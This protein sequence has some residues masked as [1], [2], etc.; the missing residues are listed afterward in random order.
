MLASH[1]VTISSTGSCTITAT[2]T[3]GTE[4]GTSNS[5][6][7]SASVSKFNACH[8]YATTSCSTASGKLYTRLAGTAFATDVAALNSSDAVATGFTGKAVVSLIARATPGGVDADNCFAPDASQTLDN[9]VTSFTSGKLTVNA[10]VASAYREAR[11]KVVCDSTN[12]PPGGVT[13]CSADNFAIRPTAI[14]LS[15]TDANADTSG[16][17]AS[18]TPAVKTGTSFNLTA[19]AVASYNGTPQIDTA[20]LNAHAGAVQAGSL[21]GSFGAAAPGTGIATGSFA[22]SEVGYFNLSASGLYDDSY[23][24]V[25]QPNDCTNDFSNVPASGKYGCKFR[26]TS[27]SVFVGRFVPDHF[28]LTAGSLIDR[29]GI[30]TGASET[31]CASSFTYMGESFKTIF[32]LEAQN[33]GN[34]TTQNYTGAHA[35]FGLTTWSNY[36]F[37]GSSGTLAEGSA[38]P[39]GNWGSTV[40]TYGKA[41]VTATHKVTRPGSPAAPYTNFVVSAQPSYTDGSA[42]YS[43]AASTAVHPGNTLQRYGRLRILGAYGSEL[44]PLRVPVRAEYHDG[45]TWLA[46]AADNCTSLAANTVALSGGISTNTSASAVSL[47]GGAGTLTLAKPSPTATGLVDL[48]INLGA[49]GTTNTDSC[50]ATNPAATAANMPWLQFAWCTGKL[51]PNAR[52]RFGSPRAPFIYLRERF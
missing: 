33:S 49:T 10:T 18:A 40:G 27:A 21:T 22:Y 35:R 48:S 43:L 47:S 36:S 8:D 16:S 2:R 11:I 51:D 39:S 31:T 52:V 37:T 45:T 46:N 38:A 26:N 32:T 23:T 19:T 3:I 34:S 30:N 41:D 12:C 1:S 15:S 42:T 5:F 14:T 20:L 29:A 4:N 9:A 24:S 50:N 28:A 6:T 7:V 25:D 17:S 13:K 44:L